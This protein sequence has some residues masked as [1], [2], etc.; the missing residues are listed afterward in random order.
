MTLIDMDQG[1]ATGRQTQQRTE[2]HM[3]SLTFVTFSRM[4]GSLGPTGAVNQSLL[5]EPLK[6]CSF[7]II[8]LFP[9]A[10]GSWRLKAGN[11]YSFPLRV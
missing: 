5:E 11:R 1:C 9:D 2:T 4:A 6:H 8:R 10:L 7:G 3:T